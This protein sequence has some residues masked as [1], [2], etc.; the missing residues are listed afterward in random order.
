MKKKLA[1]LLAVVMCLTLL[2][3]CG[4]SGSN[5]DSG[6]QAGTPSSTDSTDSKDSGS[7]SN[8]PKAPTYSW[9]MATTETSDRPVTRAMQ[10]FADAVAEATDGDIQIEV[11]ADGLLGDYTTNFEELMLGSL[12][13]QA[14]TISTDYDDRLA[15]TRIPYLCSNYAEV[16]TNM[17]EG[18]FFYNGLNE[19]MNDLGVEL[20]S[21]WPAGFQGIGGKKVGD[22]STLFDPTVK[23]NAI[24]RVPSIV[25][26]LATCEAFGFQTVTIGY[27]DLYS[28]LQTGMCDCW[29]GGTDIDTANNFPDVS[30]IYVYANYILATEPVAINKDLYDSLPEEYQRILKDCAEAELAVLCEELPKVTEESAK[31][32]EKLGIETYTPTDEEL[33]SFAEHV[34]STVWTNVKDMLGEEYF[35]GLMDAFHI[36]H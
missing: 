7:G 3:G 30:S 34:R 36:E 26:T 6:S 13:M 5:S 14:N 31:T 9:Q 11:V 21:N 17:C 19:V 27:S 1:L 23:Q 33:N 32:L 2:A 18:S 10:R 12:E 35:N 22:L 15:M 8:T 4:G 20:L 24:C 25:T 28:A 29:M 16:T